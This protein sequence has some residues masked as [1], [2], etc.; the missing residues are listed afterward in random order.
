MENFIVSNMLTG[1]EQ[2]ISAF[3]PRRTLIYYA[4]AAGMYGNSIQMSSNI[5]NVPFF[6]KKNKFFCSHINNK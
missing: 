6:T 1:V 2:A 4:T 3:K 5:D